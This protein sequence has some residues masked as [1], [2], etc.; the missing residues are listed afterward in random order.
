MKKITVSILLLVVSSAVW[1]F[2]F[3]NC[4]FEDVQHFEW[5]SQ[6]AWVELYETLDKDYDIGPPPRS[7]VVLSRTKINSLQSDQIVALYRIDFT[8]GDSHVYRIFI[9]YDAG[10]SE[11]SIGFEVE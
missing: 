4:F 3:N 6:E 11:Y 7:L 8:D 1:P 10:G 2:D 9:W 5:V